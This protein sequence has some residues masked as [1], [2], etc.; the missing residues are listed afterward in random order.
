M[1][2]TEDY[3]I[4]HNLKKI[5]A[6]INQGSYL[7]AFQAALKLYNSFP[8]DNKVVVQLAEVYKRLNNLSN[9]PLIFNNY[10]EINPE[11]KQA[12]LFFGKFLFDIK[13]WN[14]SIDILSYFMPQEEPLVYFFIGYS[15]Y[16][17][18]DYE[19]AEHNFLIF[20]DNYKE[21]NLVTESYFFLVKV[22]VELK[23]WDKALLYSKKA[24]SIYSNYWDYLYL[25]AI[26]YYNKDMIV[27]A[28]TSINKL[29]KLKSNDTAILLL[30]GKVY[31][32]HFEY[33]NALTSLEKYIELSENPSYEAYSYLGD[34][35][36]A[37]KEYEKAKDM[38]STAF[39][40]NPLYAYAEEKEKLVLNI[41]GNKEN[42][43][44][45]ENSL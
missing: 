30:A 31:Y 35:Y 2:M 39:K 20:I 13:L 44:S 1:G 12:R 24:E 14:E 28:A 22:Y 11:D 41:L 16:M 25:L 9:I 21:S 32:K 15:Y 37:T 4:E 6:L 38:F 36:F 8:E 19:L 3:Q 5:D 27:H 26:I 34:V 40:L 7:K 23:E 18:K 33:K 10:L 45:N 43:L 42:P 29:L 17:V